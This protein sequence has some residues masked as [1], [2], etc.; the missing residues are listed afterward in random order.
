MGKVAEGGRDPGAQDGA[1][2]L[3]VAGDDEGE[4]DCQRRVGGEGGMWEYELILLY[5]RSI[6]LGS[7]GR[8][9]L[10]F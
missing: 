2:P 8:G 10:K 3:A 1:E 6:P 4:D 5:R 7:G 9:T